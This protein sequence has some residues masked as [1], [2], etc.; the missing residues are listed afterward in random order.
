MKKE[1]LGE[2]KYL[3]HSEL[4]DRYKLA[5][6]GGFYFECIMLVYNYLEDRLAAFLHYAGIV[7]ADSKGMGVHSVAKR[8]VRRLM[9]LEQSQQFRLHEIK[10]KIILVKCL[11]G[12]DIETEDNPLLIAIGERVEE[13]LDREA[14]LD[15]L[16]RCRRWK[17]QRNTYVHG[18]LRKYNLQGEE[19][20]REYVEEGMK[21]GRE[22]DS[23]V[24]KFKP[25]KG[26]KGIREHFK[27]QTKPL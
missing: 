11:M 15:T 25:G 10:N 6:K 4:H 16:E 1:E 19:N 23:Y 9:G 14:V 5:M 18:F 21:I 17:D 24:R 8:P 2:V 26:K 3:K 12:I 22:L 13:R 7:D 27:L 20:L